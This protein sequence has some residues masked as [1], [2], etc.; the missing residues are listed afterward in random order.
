MK[1]WFKKAAAAAAAAL[2]LAG[3]SLQ[4]S[5]ATPYD[6]YIYDEEEVV[7]VPPA[8]TPSASIDHTAMG[9]TA[10]KSPQDLFVAPDGYLYV[11]DTGNNRILKLD[12]QYALQKEFR[13]FLN[14][15]T[16]D[17]FAS[18]SGIF[19]DESGNLLVADTDNAR[20]VR[21]DPE[22]NLLAVYGEPESP[23]LPADFDYRPIKV[24][25]DSAG[26]IFVAS[27]GFN[28]GLLELD[29]QGVFVQMLG[30]SQVTYSLT[31]MIWRLFST[32][33]QR[34]RMEAFVPAEYNNI[35]VDAEDFIFVTTGTYD[36]DS[37]GES[38][39]PVRR[40]N[41]KGDDVLRRVGNP[42]ADEEFTELSSIKGPSLVV[43]VANLNH[44]LYA[45]LDQKRGRVFVYNVDGVML[46]MFGGLGQ[47]FGT[48]TTPA[49]LAYYND[50]FLVLDAGKNQIMSYEL[51]EY[52]RLIF[53]AEEY[54]D[55]NNY[56]KEK[57]TWEA[58][59]GFN[60]NNP[61]VLQ[62]MGKIAY[63][64]RDMKLAME[65]FRRCDDKANYSKAFQ[66]Y[67][68]DLINQ[69][70]TVG[71]ILVIVVLAALL[72]LH[73]FLRQRRKKH[74]KE[75]KKGPFRYATYVIFRPFDGFW[76][77]KRENRGSLKAGLALIGLAGLA[78]I[79]QTQVTGFIF[80]PTQP[81]DAN[82][83]IDLATLFI[84]LLLWVTSSWCVTSLMDGE[85][86]FKTIVMSSGYAL[87]PLVILLPVASLISNVMTETEGAIYYFLVALAY[88]WMVGL[89]IASVRQI[90]NYS[91][92]KALF[93]ILVT[94]V[95]ILIIVFV[96]LLCTALLQQMVAF[97]A[98]IYSELANRA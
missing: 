95:V 43:D 79:F 54:K 48:L 93:V 42:V 4:A 23:L 57:E 41:A 49:S 73:F 85:G 78:L 24:A 71:G 63:R 97:F 74:P 27:R 13:T 88:I 62:E 90:H 91:M 96:I 12:K 14:N 31:E 80:N 60:E 81:E 17:S 58:V 36:E 55:D 30:A 29:R 21:L 28:R 35:S 68:R 84:P 1:R 34:D 39:T 51:T 50:E 40:I 47:T 77:L 65:Y 26:R 87:T 92:G 19:V 45:I 7:P 38:M 25:G 8:A 3:L 94:L 70:F 61:V 9:T 33:A 32:D 2:L 37:S 76:D 59:L 20:L 11:A 69:Y 66:F 5:A 86:S 46:F 98:D 52:A 53:L 72:A 6:N 64:Q 44:G 56:E 75:K 82:F 89:M 83:L 10:L 22:G 67:R 16:E 18:P 15:G